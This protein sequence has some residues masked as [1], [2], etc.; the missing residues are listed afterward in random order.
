MNYEII[1]NEQTLIDFVDN[2]LPELKENEKF[3]CCLFARKKYSPK[4]VKSSDKT[5]LKRFLTN[6]ELLIDKLKQ[7]EI[8]IG[9]WKIKGMSAPQESLVVYIN[10]NPRCMK[11]A[12]YK[13]MKKCLELLETD[14]KGYN[15]NAESL[16][17]VQNSKS[18]G[19]FVDFDI[20]QKE[21]VD[22]SILKE[23]FPSKY[24]PYKILE[25]RGGYHLLVEAS[26][27]ENT[28]KDWYRKVINSFPL[29]QAG[30]NMIPIPGCVQGGFVP[31]FINT[32]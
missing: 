15:V 19:V 21:N 10:P 12:T 11:K 14:A 7:L 23:I 8:P 22:F 16:S 24:N 6:K 5:Q 26:R 9:K 29:D 32:T 20:D 30:D 28:N 17:A 2:F 13:L 31:K 25:T 1:K 18:R 27:V 3:Y 4:L